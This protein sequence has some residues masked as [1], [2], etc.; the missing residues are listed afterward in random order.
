VP[1]PHLAFCVAAVLFVVYVSAIRLHASW[2]DRR[3]FVEDLRNPS[4]IAGIWN[5]DEMTTGGQVRPP[6]TTDRKRWR[7]FIVEG[8]YTTAMQ[9]MDDSQQRYWLTLDEK[10]KTIAL[11]FHAT[12]LTLN[13]DRPDAQTLLLNGMVEGKNITATLHKDN[14]RTFLLTSRGFHW[15]NE[16]PF[17]Q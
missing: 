11:Q 4:P 8:Q 16:K 10:K 6:L 13:Y 14:E 15:I 17:N 1:K 3:E 12:T 9:S 2:K 7:R 5:V